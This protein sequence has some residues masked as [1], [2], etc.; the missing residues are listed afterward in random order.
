MITAG[1]V[2]VNGQIVT[3]LGVKVDAARDSVAVD[4]AE[5]ELAAR[6]YWMLHKPVGVITTVDDPW[7]R[8]TARD[9]IPTESRV[10]PVG[11]LDAASSGLLLFTNDGEL[12]YR[13]THPSFEHPK[14]YHVLVE[15]RPGSDDLRRLRRGLRLDGRPTA[16]AEVEV[17]GEN[18]DGT[19]LRVV[20][21]EGRK[22][23]VRRMMAKVK[24]PVVTLVRVRLG[25]LE[26]GSLKPGDARRLSPDERLALRQLLDDR[27]DEPQTSRRQQ[28]SAGR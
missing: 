10:F 28:A 15:G 18:A 8:P 27:P 25:P 14:E 9:L 5:V 2:A 17:L 1:R 20:L 13:L 26:L 12:A 21:H 22:R 16:P 4:G 19:W 23:Q 3:Q 11:R 24:H 6:E 7:G